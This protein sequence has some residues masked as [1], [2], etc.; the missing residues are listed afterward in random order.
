MPS[1][2]GGSWGKSWGNSWGSDG[3]FRQYAIHFLSREPISLGERGNIVL[4]PKKALT[5][6][7]IER[8]I[9]FNSRPNLLVMPKMAANLKQRHSIEIKH[10]KDIIQKERESIALDSQNISV[11]KVSDIEVKE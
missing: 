3:K 10:N 6:D 2:W 4:S 5:F 1:A 7:S 11:S 9:H 8:S